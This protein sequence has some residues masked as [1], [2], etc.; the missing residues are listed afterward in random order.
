MEFIT[1]DKQSLLHE[2]KYYYGLGECSGD[3]IKRFFSFEENKI[4]DL[5]QALIEYVLW[6]KI[7]LSFPPYKK[8]RRTF[9][10]TVI[11]TVERSNN[12]VDGTIFEDYISLINQVQNSNEEKYFLVVFSK[13]FIKINRD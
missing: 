4:W 2:I 9:L 11:E 10:K 5:Q 8:Y 12:E 3:L 13:V 1:P 7:L 6:D